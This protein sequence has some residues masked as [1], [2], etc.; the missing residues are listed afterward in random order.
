VT[1]QKPLITAPIPSLVPM[2]AAQSPQPAVQP[3]QPATQSAPPAEVNW[4]KK[5]RHHL[6]VKALSDFPPDERACYECV[7]CQRQLPPNQVDESLTIAVIGDV[8]AG[9]THFITALLQ[10]LPLLQVPPG[11]GYIKGRF[12]D[13]AIERRYMANYYQHLFHHR[14]SFSR[15]QIAT[16][17]ILDPWIYELKIERA[18]GTKTIINLVIYDASGED[19][20]NQSSLFQYHSHILRASAI[21]YLLDPGQIKKFLDGLRHGKRP[22]EQSVSHH[23]TQNLDWA[24]DAF[25]TANPRLK[26]SPRFPLPTAIVFPKIDLLEYHNTLYQKYQYLWKPEY[27]R[28]Y[29]LDSDQIHACTRE[30]LRDLEQQNVLNLERDLECMKFFVASATGSAPLNG[31]FQQE[32]KPHRCLDP[33]LWLLRQLNK[34]D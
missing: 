9:K 4:L 3:T 33:L 13:Q 1:A 32:I 21:L 12:A 18:D 17:S 27:A 22:A 19:L 26:E 5:F 6:L 34:I 25:E 2:P 10:Q 29:N 7:H 30:L 24:I 20:Y 11:Y 16:G 15:T 28:T 14:K 23:A 8:T 31:E